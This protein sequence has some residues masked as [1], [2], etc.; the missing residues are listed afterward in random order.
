MRRLSAKIQ[1]STSPVLSSQTLWLTVCHPACSCCLLLKTF[2][3]S[4]DNEEETR[5]CAC[6]REAS[7][8]IQLHLKGEAQLATT[9]GFRAEVE[10]GDRVVK[11][12]KYDKFLW[13]CLSLRPPAGC[14]VFMCSVSSDT[15]R[16]LFK[17]DR[18]LK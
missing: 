2:L 18:A 17:T 5:L 1:C 6:P 8:E 4:A 13:L 7:W 15:C 9:H 3:H 10:L 16:G 14:H 12:C 11:M